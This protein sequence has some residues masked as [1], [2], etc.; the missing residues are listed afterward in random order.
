MSDDN[1]KKNKIDTSKENT[2]EELPPK[3]KKAIDELIL[4]IKI[5]GPQMS[6][7]ERAKSVE[8]PRGGYVKRVDFEEIPIGP[9]E[10]ALHEDEN[11]HASL[12]GMAVDY[13][14]RFILTGDLE[15]SFKI[16]ILGA[17][18]INKIRT[19]N[20]LLKGISGLDD[21]SIINAIKLSGFDVI[22]RGNIFGY[23]PVNQIKPNSNT[24][25]NVRTMVQ[26]TVKFFEQYG[27]IVSDGFSFEGG[28]TKIIAKGDADYLSADTI[29]DLKVLKNHFTKNHIMQLLIYW[30]MGLRSDYE[31][32]K[33]IKYIGIY[34]PRKN[35]VFIYDL[36]KLPYETIQ[37]IDEVVIGYTKPSL[38]YF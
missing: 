31:K 2:Y 35:K 18:K 4:V 16:S 7:T 30:R 3:L 27:P 36:C 8:Q 32:F 9:G 34:N 5:Y 22:Y 26:R 29:W 25:E 11:V 28:Y 24:A 21:Q 33:K 6:V 19:A 13:L 38:I 14:T 10:E 23:I 12:I 37:I 20:R 1:I 17:K 15:D